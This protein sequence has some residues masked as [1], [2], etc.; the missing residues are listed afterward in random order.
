MLTAK[1]YRRGPPATAGDIAVTTKNAMSMNFR[2][3]SI[4]PAASGRSI[5]P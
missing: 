3:D 4:S 2:R 5:K 1:V